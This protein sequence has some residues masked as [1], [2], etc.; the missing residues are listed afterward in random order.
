MQGNSQNPH[1]TVLTGVLIGEAPQLQDPGLRRRLLQRVPPRGLRS[2][3][4]SGA[5]VDLE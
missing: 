3:Q 5:Q 2:G 1:K 4:R